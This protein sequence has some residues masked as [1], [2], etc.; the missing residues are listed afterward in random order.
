MTR[1]TLGVLATDPW[2]SR[3][4]SGAHRPAPAVAYRLDADF[5]HLQIQGVDLKLRRRLRRGGG[6][7]QDSMIGSSGVLPAAA[8]R[9]Q[10][11]PL[12]APREHFHQCVH[13]QHDILFWRL[14]MR[15]SMNMNISPTVMVRTQA[16]K[17]RMSYRLF[18]SGLLLS[19]A[20]AIASTPAS[21]TW[22]ITSTSVPVA[23]FSSAWII[24][25]ASG[26]S[27]ACRQATM[28]CTRAG[29][30]GRRS[31]PPAVGGD[32]NKDIGVFLL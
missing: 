32:H 21:R 26:L 13:G 16:K 25:R 12:V 30:P 27:A 7:L 18:S 17:K 1:P 15:L 20:T 22:S 19:A 4:A 23:A 3:Y 6:S 28:A 9:A 2:W 29:R 14:L 24:T 31:I 5:S 8:R 10:V 11:P